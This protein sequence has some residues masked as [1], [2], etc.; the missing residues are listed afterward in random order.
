MLLKHLPAESAVSRSVHGEAAD[1][2][3]SDHLLAAVVDHLAVSN[4]M[5]ASANSEEGDQQDPPKPVP[6]PGDASNDA[7]K[8][9]EAGGDAAAPAPEEI[10]RFFG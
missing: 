6:R 5:F 8:D 9:A 2:S 7:A 4:W 1:W 10:A 3:V